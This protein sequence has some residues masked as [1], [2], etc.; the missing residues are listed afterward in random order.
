MKKRI[1]GKD[2]LTDDKYPDGFST[3]EIGRITTFKL[4]EDQQNFDTAIANLH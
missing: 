2:E 3:S 1:E 4:A